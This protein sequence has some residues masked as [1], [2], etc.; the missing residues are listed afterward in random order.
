[1]LGVNWILCIEVIGAI[2]TSE[3]AP[4]A[5]PTVPARYTVV[6][7]ADWEATVRLLLLIMPP[8]ARINFAESDAR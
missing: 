8:D 1:M 4:P 3:P 6:N 5:V 7:A 2:N